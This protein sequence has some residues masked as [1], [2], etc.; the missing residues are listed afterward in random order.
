MENKALT[1]KKKKNDKSVPGYDL[2]KFLFNA[3]DR[4]NQQMHGKM[5]PFRHGGNSRMG[6][7]GKEGDFAL[8]VIVLN[9]FDMYFEA[10][11]LPR[12]NFDFKNLCIVLSDQIWYMFK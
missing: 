12:E 4:Y 2:Y 5:W 11:G 7:E 1:V 8:S 9:T 6:A 3:C 10:R